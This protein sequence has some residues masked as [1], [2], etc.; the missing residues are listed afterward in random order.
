MVPSR[1]EGL[2]IMGVGIA[3]GLALGLGIVFFLEYLEGPL[4]HEVDV[5]STTRIPIIGVLPK[6]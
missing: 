1:S 4:R 2:R 6:I 5:E 3:L